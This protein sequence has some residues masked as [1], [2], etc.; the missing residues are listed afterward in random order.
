MITVYDEE[1]ERTIRERLY[2]HEAAKQS[3]EREVVV[4]REVIEEEDEAISHL[5]FVLADYRRMH[6]LRACSG[7]VSPVLAAEYGHLGPTELVERWADGHGGE[8]RVKELAG[9]CMDAGAAFRDVWSA[10][11]SVYAV[12]RRKNFVKLGPGRFARKVR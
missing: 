6:G 10:Y 2:A 3:A 11:A 4:A 12:L 1:V 7:A 8:V 9:I 5:W